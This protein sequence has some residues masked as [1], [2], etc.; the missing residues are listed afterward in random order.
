MVFHRH[1][2]SLTVCIW[3]SVLGFFLGGCHRETSQPVPPPKHV[4]LI[5]VDTLRADHLSL[6]G[7]P[8]LTSPTLDR[9][10]T[11]SVVFE[12][13]ISQWPKTG[14]S[15]ASIFTGLYPQ[16]TG[17]THEAALRVPEKYLT[18]PEFL[19]SVGFTT[20]AVVT[21]SVL[22]SHLD[23]NR[24]FDEYVQTWDLAP[25]LSTKPAENRPWINARRVNELAIPLFEKYKNTRRLFVW[26]HYSDPHAPY[27][28][29]DDVPNPFLNDRYYTGDRKA[30]FSSGSDQ[31]VLGKHRELR[32]YTAQYDANIRFMDEQIGHVLDAAQQRD[33]LDDSLLVLTADHGESLGEHKYFFAHGNLPYNDGVHVPLMMSSPGLLFGGER[34]KEPV[35]LVDLFPTLAA[36]LAPTHPIPSFDGDNLL[37]WLTR[38]NASRNTSEF[39]TPRLAFSQ[40]GYRSPPSHYRSVQD[41][42]WKLIYGR[43][44]KRFKGKQ[45]S[46]W[47]LY[48]MLE[49]PGEVRSV[50]KKEARQEFKRLKK[51]LKTWTEGS[52]WILPPRMELDTPDPETVRALR[53]MGYL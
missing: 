22:G 29:P 17:L 25:E 23:W 27:L 50:P 39:Q 40:A 41:A 53:A 24:G 15:F 26:L 43:F 12:T 48:D 21:N 9:L 3:I 45:P 1:Q 28:L 38:Q 5:T 30:R 46:R 11:T 19:R 20:V 4:F 49:D 2:E 8:R 34:H 13:A 14:T 10:A 18:L 51:E 32:Y 7:Y 36:L 33:L 31:A 16:T 44:G 47:R 35:E 6:Y 52:S 42:R 37:P